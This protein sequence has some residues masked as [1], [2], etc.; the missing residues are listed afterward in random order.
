[1][2]NE[3]VESIKLSEKVAKFERMIRRELMDLPMQEHRRL[4]LKIH[5]K[6]E[7]IS[8]SILESGNVPLGR[9]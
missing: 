9:V 4:L 2:V 7:E 6:L 8:L 5:Q 1:M 3:R